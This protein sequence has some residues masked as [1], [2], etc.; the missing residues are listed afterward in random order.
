MALITLMTLKVILSKQGDSPWNDVYF[1]NQSVSSICSTARA[2]ITKNYILL[3]KVP[4]VFNVTWFEMN[5]SR[6]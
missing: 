1:H 2:A 4:L 6:S 5:T 3:R